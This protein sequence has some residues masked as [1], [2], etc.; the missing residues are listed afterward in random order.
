MPRKSGRSP[1]SSFPVHRRGLRH[2]FRPTVG[3][4]EDRRL[5]SLSPTF[6]S[7]MASAGQAVY[8]NPVTFTATVSGLPYTGATPSS[9]V[10]TFYDGSMVLGVT[11]LSSGVATLTT[12]SLDLGPQTISAVYSGDGQTFA[13]SSS[14]IIA[15]IAGNLSPGDSNGTGLATSARLDH[16]GG[17]AL[18]ARGDLFIAD[19]GNNVVREVTP[20]GTMT[21]VVG[22]GQ[23]GYSGDGGP[24]A[25][26]ELNDPTSL[27]MDTHGDLFIVDN[28]NG[29][30][31]EVTPGPDGLLS[32]GTV[33]TLNVLIGYLSQLGSVAVDARGDLFIADPDGAVQEVT[34][35]PDGLA[36]GTITTI[37]ANDFNLPGS[38]DFNLSTSVAVDA[39]GDLFVGDDP[40]I[41]EIAPGPDGRL[42]DGTITNVARGGGQEVIGLAVDANGDVFSTATY[43]SAV[44]ETQPG[45]DGLLSDRFVSDVAGTGPPGYTAGGGPAFAAGLD[46]SSSVAVDAH[47]NLFIA[48][49][50]NNVVEEV[51]LNATVTVLPVSPPTA[52]A[53]VTQVTSSSPSAALGSG[54]DLVFNATVML[55]ASGGGT[56]TGTIQFVVDGNDV[57]GPLPLDVNGAASITLNPLSLGL[58]NHALSAV[59]TSN[60][61]SFAGNTTTFPGGV[62]VYSPTTTAVIASSSEAVAGQLVMFTATVTPQALDGFTPSGTAQFLIDGKNFGAPVPITGGQASMTTSALAPGY[63]SV[64]AIYVSNSLAFTGS[65]SPLQTT[66]VTGV[67][68]GRYQLSSGSAGA[69]PLSGPNGL[70]LDARGD[71]FIADEGGNAVLEMKPDGIVTAI[72]GNGQ[73]G[74][75]GDGGPPADAELNFP[76]TLAMDARGDL[77]IADVNN[78]AVREV[79]PGAD[80]LPSDGTIITVAGSGTNGDPNFTGPADLAALTY[81]NGIAVDARGDLFIADSGNSVVREVTLGPDGLL[82]DGTI[83][84]VAGDGQAGY[85]GDGG[86]ATAAMLS[87][88]NA[89]A[90][91]AAG[92]LFIADYGNGVV[93]E[94]TPDGTIT[95]FAGNGTF[96]YSG[97]GGPAASAELNTPNGLALDSHGDLLI[98]DAY[99]GAVRMVDP[100]GTITTVASGLNYPAG[101][102]V[103]GAGDLFIADHNNNVI[104]ELTSGP[105]GLLADG[106]LAVAAGV[107]SPGLINSTG[108]AVDAQG[109]VYVADQLDGVV[110]EVKPGGLLSTVVS[111]LNQPSG[112]ALDTQGDLFIADT[113]DNTVREL[114][115]GP[116]GLLSDGTLLTVV[117]TGSAGYSGDGGQ[118]SNASL[119]L[120]TGMTFDDH[121]DLFLSDSGNNVVREVTPGP[122][123]FIA[124]GI[125]TTV[126]NIGTFPGSPIPFWNSPSD[127]SGLAVDARGDLFIA[128]TGNGTVLEETPGPDGLVPNSTLSLVDDLFDGGT[129]VPSGLAIDA[130]GDLFIEDLNGDFAQILEV[131]P[132]GLIRSVTSFV[133]ES[134]SD[135]SGGTIPFFIRD[136]DG[137]QVEVQGLAVDSQG[138]LIFAQYPGVGFVG[139]PGLTVLANAANTFATTTSVTS[140]SATSV[141]GQAVT[142]TAV[143]SSQDPISDTPTGTVT[144]LAGTTALD[145]ETLSDGTASFTTSALA[146][147]SHTITAV[148]GGDADFVTSPSA[149]LTQQINDLNATSLE[150]AIAA[151]QS[152]GGTVVLAPATTSTLTST[153]AAITDLP[154]SSS[155]A[156]SVEL[157]NTAIYAQYDSMGNVIPI[158]ASV[159]SGVTLTISCSSGSATVYDLQPSGGNV[160]IHGVPGQG[161]ITIIGRSPALTVDGGNVTVGPGVT[162][163][164]TTDSPTV[165]VNGGTLSLRGALVEE[166]SAYAQTTILING[167]TVDL[168][169]ASSPGGNTFDVNGDGAFLGN[170]TSSPLADV[171]NTLEVNGVPLSAAYLSL[172]TLGSSAPSSGLGQPVTLTATVRGAN[173]A[174]GSPT[175][176]VDFVDTTTG[177]DLGT[178]ILTQGV[179]TLT[180][181]TL[182]IGGHTIAA[183]YEGDGQFAFSARGLTQAV[184]QAVNTSTDVSASSNPSVFGQSVTFTATVHSASNGSDAPTGSVQFVID[185]TPFGP[186][187][188]LSGGVASVND[189]ALSAGAH[190]VIADYLGNTGFQT[191]TSALT[192]TVHQATPTLSWSNPPDILYGTALSSAQLDASASV[193]GTFTYTPAPGT[194]LQAGTGQTLTVSFTPTDAVD[195]SH[196][197]RSVLI[198]VAKATLTVT[199]NKATKVYGSVNP[200]FMA[201]YSGFVNND[202]SGVLSGSPSLTTNATSTSPV[203][204]YLITAT[205]GTLASANYTFAFVNSTL[206]ITTLAGSI[207]VLDPTAGGALSLSG[208]A[209]INTLGNLV[210]DSHSSTAILA[211]GNASVTAAS[212]QVVGGVSK[213][214][215]AAVTKTGTPGATGD[216]LAGLAGPTVP[217]YSGSPLSENVGGNT[218]TTINPGLYSQITVSGNAQLTLTPGVYVLAGGGFTA[219]GNAVV[220]ASNVTFIIEGGGFSQSGNATVKG[221]GVTIFNAGSNYGTSGSGG[222]YGPITLSGNGN[223]SAP[224]TGPYAGILIFQSRDNTQTLSF[225]GNTLLEMTG[226]IYAE[227][228]PLV[229]SGNAQLGSSQ[230][231]LSLVVDRMTL[232]GN[233]IADGLTLAA[234]SGTHPYTPAQIRA[235]Y[236]SNSLSEDGTGQTIAIV[237]AYNDPDIGIALDTFDSQF[238]LTSNGQTLYQQYGPA[239]SFLTVLNQSGQPTSLPATDPSGPGTD[240]WEVE[241]ALDVEWAHAIAP[242]AKILLVEANSQSLSDLMAGVVTAAQQPGVS[243]VSMSWGFPE[244][245]DVFA[246]D[247][248]TYDRDFSVPGVTFV[249]STGD[250]GAADPEYP[251]YSPNVVAV[252]GTSLTL[253]AENTYQ[254]ETAWGY[255]SAAAGTFIGSGGGLSLYEPMPAYQQG[256][257]STGSRTTPDVSL[258]ADPATGAWIADPYNLDPSN[259]FEVVGGT[260]LSAPA[261][262]GLLALVNQGRV[263]AGQPTLNSASP[264]ETLQAL[265]SLPQSDYN[266][267]ASGTNGYTAHTGYNL[268]TGLGTPSVNHLVPDLVAYNGSGTTYPGTPVAPLLDATLTA[269]SA[270]SGGTNNVF[271]V[272]DSF[273]VTSS[274]LGD[275]SNPMLGSGLNTAPNATL[276]PGA[277]PSAVTGPSVVSSSLSLVSGLPHR[278]AF[279]ASLSTPLTITP[280]SGTVSISGTGSVLW[281]SSAQV[282]PAAA[283]L[284]GG[285]VLPGALTERSRPSRTWAD[286]TNAFTRRPLDQE[287]ASIR[288]VGRDETRFEE[289]SARIDDCSRAMFWDHALVAYLAESEET[290]PSPGDVNLAADDT[291]KD[292]AASALE[293]LLMA[294]S[295]VVLWG[296]WEIR[297]RS[298]DRRSH[299]GVAANRLR[300]GR[301]RA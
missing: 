173:P 149:T 263:A 262:A 35:G 274:A 8:G 79:I 289:A 156:V 128:V 101:L 171:G 261:W 159:S 148:Y 246:S 208:N 165:L 245:Q 114:T 33:I 61:S 300:A 13:G 21:T 111:G 94:V 83:T 198:N 196:A 254:S 9:G 93:R 176:V 188:T 247:E 96:G 11:G 20:D 211:S 223:L 7:V 100:S 232:S 267:I 293:S 54:Q 126:A 189:G 14:G 184:N 132:D 158:E 285:D 272:F 73:A 241:E 62:P 257:Q 97:D 213:S 18:D 4:L 135:S 131:P 44:F 95:T 12:T 234:P 255:D 163:I 215:N 24:A 224:T 239:A 199:A 98:S 28:G 34:P 297:S 106:Q 168:G 144:F 78:N 244:G 134:E 99:N 204:G 117:G 296:S 212:V 193:A 42:S 264:T 43:L 287:Q 47:G 238:G 166:S 45:P 256:V 228:A 268:V 133:T 299:P 235:A 236:G 276:R 209:H 59:Y 225:S 252:G 102:V 187:V 164:T 6:T 40:L 63:H 23:A 16:P 277:P 150:S 127:P 169:T 67:G 178:G 250:Y 201:S 182:T 112:L 104:R 17:V 57:G 15:T 107:A 27:A 124:D 161:N 243:V 230:D 19:S 179:A 218:N 172:T 88:P 30:V 273:T 258:V 151:E 301:N 278:A 233:A 294:G 231:P 60:S 154:L 81:P 139:N 51:G 77:L 242:G 58:G 205:Q 1:R 41:F 183:D 121:G 295:A 39:H 217:G 167:G 226:T 175:G 180:T 155:G 249:A 113:R 3:R 197:F 214:G 85:S 110:S 170:T 280:Q 185:G 130:Q 119:Y 177:T 84:T 253:N 288:F 142:F 65:T 157:G 52:P 279:A 5:L 275:A 290:G 22:N 76:Q 291:S 160:D 283:S 25:D 136:P 265:Y 141:A 108:V 48:D 190:N 260:S 220:T 271:S 181:S 248:A 282:T 237:D 74:Y 140:S 50:D 162:L 186:A 191:S 90:V 64:S 2:G 202:T 37:D 68:A 72:A 36:D 192:E 292:R 109:N 89:V 75:S 46:S 146:V 10:V 138:E 269:T 125:I 195:F 116:D 26:A 152:S 298:G 222:T 38:L 120:P 122:D 216:P 56:P 251:A 206:S 194:V 53:T 240:N 137:N 227:A 105:D 123:G 87:N 147:G 153:L 103:D 82:S 229:Q 219:S 32:D 221:A 259:P 115:P 29:I 118:A 286:A 129:G 70:A 270:N 203:G 174:D 69:V 143:V 86:P 55:A 66:G 284:Q 281:S 207:Y 80:G 71:L 210:V 145:T 49:T 91:D 266:V 31:R 92:D 200:V